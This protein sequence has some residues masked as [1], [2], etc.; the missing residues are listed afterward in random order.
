MAVMVWKI[1]TAMHSRAG[2]SPAPRST[3]S[4]GEFETLYAVNSKRVTSL[5]SQDITN[6]LGVEMGRLM[7][8]LRPR[9]ACYGLRRPQRRYR[10]SALKKA[11][12][13]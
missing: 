8:P 13:L 7:V 3:A 9:T 6:P 10:P 12:G 2:K 11:A 4:V 1:P 5:G